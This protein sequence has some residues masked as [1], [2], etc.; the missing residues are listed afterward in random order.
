MKRLSSAMAA[1]LLA[2]VSV[3]ADAAVTDYAFDS[4]SKVDFQNDRISITG[5]L[6]NTTA[7]FTLTLAENTNGDFRYIVS[8]CVPVLLTMLEK[9]G[10]FYLNVTGDTAATNIGLSKC[11]LETRS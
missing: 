11:G 7:P 5:V 3:G 1:V 9:P 10:K 6:R 8:R 4:V 2:S